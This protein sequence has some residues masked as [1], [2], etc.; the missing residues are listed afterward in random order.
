MLV[1]SEST[2]MQLKRQLEQLQARWERVRACGPCWP[3]EVV[4]RVVITRCVRV[5]RGALCVVRG[6]WCLVRDACVVR[7]MMWH[8]TI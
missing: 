2:A 6:A 7:A 3:C 4:C 8:T 1:E 5:V